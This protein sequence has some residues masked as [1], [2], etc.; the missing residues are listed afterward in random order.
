[1]NREPMCGRCGDPLEVVLGEER[2]ERAR[3]GQNLCDA[4]RE[5][6]REEKERKLLRIIR[7]A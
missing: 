2:L 4:C 7:E 5:E 6:V 1:M 3:K